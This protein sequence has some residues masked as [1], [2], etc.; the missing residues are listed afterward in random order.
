MPTPAFFLYL[1]AV[2]AAW[3]LRLSYVGWFG[4]YLLSCVIFVPLVLSLLSFPAMFSLK[5][6]VKLSPTVTKGSE[7]SLLLRFSLSPLLP[8]CRVIAAV[9]IENRYTGERDRLRLET[10]DPSAEEL[11]FALPTDMCGQLRCRVLRIEC[12]DLLGLFRIR[13]RLPDEMLCTVLPFPAAPDAAPDL[14]ASLETAPILKPKYGG[15]YSEE[16]ELREYRPGDSINT[17]H[18]KLSSKMD[19]LIVREPLDRENDQIFLV[20]SRV[21]ADDRGLE[22]LRWLSGELLRRELS[23]CIIAD[24]L[25]SVENE[26]QAVEA[27]CSLLA[28]PLA[29][30]M[31]FDASMARCVFRIVDGEVRLW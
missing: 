20:L 26:Q 21:G 9:E 17:I 12:R 28:T 7:E 25:Y 11:A 8:S 14:D 4:P 30:P 27:L 13:R 24:R 15:G 18:W 19:E 31:R 10:A 6:D 5:T 23:H 16:H 1:L 29:E 22:V 3:I 2:A